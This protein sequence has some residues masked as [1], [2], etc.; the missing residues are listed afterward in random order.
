MDEPPQII[1]RPDPYE[2]PAAFYSGSAAN[3]A[4]YGEIVWWIAKRDAS[5][6]ASSLVVVPLNEL[7]VEQNPANRLLPKYTWGTKVGTRYSGANRE[8]R[9]VH[10][11]YPGTEPLALR[12]SGPLQICGAAVSVSVEAQE[13]AA[14]F[15]AEGGLPSILIKHS[16]ELSPEEDEN[17]YNEAERLRNQFMEKAH[18]VPRVIDQNIESVDYLQPGE[19]G[20]QMLESRQHQNGESARMFG[21]PGSL[22]EYQSPGSSLT[23][24]NLEGEFTKFIRVCEQPLYLEPMEQAMSDLLPRSIT[25][26][27][28]VEGF[29]RADIMTRFNVHKIAIETGVYGP[30]YAQQVEGIAPGDVEF[31]PIPFSPPAAVPSPLKAASTE[32]HDVRCPNCQRLV[33]RASGPI[34][35]WCRHCKVTVAA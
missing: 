25:A 30:E 20:A 32:M 24:Q 12:G 5:G 31:A 7:Q 4:K 23:Y 9:F 26:R 6:L 18:N 34:E 3:M 29:L 17:G 28:N 33:A 13:W 19:R 22:L 16:G 2:T 14:N 15:Y 27:F 21:V 11:K 8:G 10:V 35:G 1:L